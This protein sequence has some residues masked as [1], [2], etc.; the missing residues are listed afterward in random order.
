MN[1]KF[2]SAVLFGALMVTSTGTFVSCKDYDDDIDQINNTLTDLKSQIAALQTEVEGGN[3]VTDLVDVEG[4]FKVTFNN[5]K[6]Y[7]IVNGKDGDKGE[8]GAAGAAGDKLTIDEATGEWKINGEATGWFANKKDQAAEVYLPKI[9]GGYWYFYNTEKKEY[10]QSDYKAN[11]AAYAIDAN[12]KYTMYLPTEDGKDM[13]KI[14]LPKYALTSLELAMTSDEYSYMRY[15]VASKD[16]KDELTGVS[17]K[18]DELIPLATAD[19]KTGFD[20]RVVANPTNTDLSDCPFSLI[21]S[22]GST[23]F[24]EGAARKYDGEIIRSAVD[25]L[26]FVNFNLAGGLKADSKAFENVSDTMTKKLS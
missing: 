24:T 21:A 17:Y 26:K 20:V 13:V 6:T 2:L 25:G 1:K 10:E 8:T 7:T 16:F 9:E 5:G 22:D 15:A 12:G 19:G 23:L 14:E 4:G 18:K 3:W 11:G